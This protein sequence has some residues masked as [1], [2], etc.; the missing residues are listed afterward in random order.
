MLVQDRET[1]WHFLRRLAAYM[2]KHLFPG[3]K[4]WLGDPLKEFQDLEK[5][6]ILE[7]RVKLDI[8]RSSAVCR[9]KKHLKLGVQIQ[10]YGKNFFVDGVV[11]RKNSEE[12][13]YE[14]HLLEVEKD[15]APAELLPH[16]LSARVTDN[17][18]PKKQGRV[19]VK[20]L[21]PYEDVLESIWIP[22]GSVWASKELGIACVPWKDDLV[23]VQ[24][25]DGNAMVMQARREEAFDSRFKGPDAR[26]LFVGKNT[27]LMMDDEQIAVDNSIYTCTISG[28][29]F[30]L[31][32][33][34]NLS[35]VIEDGK[36]TTHV[37]KTDLEIA[38]GTKL[39]TQGL[40]IDGKKSVEMTASKVEIRGSNGVSIN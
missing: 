28:D 29:Q 31:R 16:L 26:Y 37:D 11:Y 20:F 2:G 34:K 21:D 10:L 14:Y 35:I 27:W 13:F 8:Q 4:N 19:K 22:C 39:I 3:E 18:D 25:F 38:D 15:F 40:Q 33:G 17:E 24:I 12:Y 9:T 5:E 23:D 30:S 7:L 32:F 1:D 6:D 36:L